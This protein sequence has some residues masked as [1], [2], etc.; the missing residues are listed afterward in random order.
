MERRL[1]LS[2]NKK[3]NNEMKEYKKPTINI[4]QV[5]VEQLL[6]SESGQCHEGKAK[7][8]DFWADE[9]ESF[10]ASSTSDD[11]N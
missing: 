10:E 7:R 6:A 9:D 1:S 8:N 11:W 5:V 4:Q 3:K 2:K